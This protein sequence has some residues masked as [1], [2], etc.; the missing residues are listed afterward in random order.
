MEDDEIFAASY[1]TAGSHPAW[2]QPRQRLVEQQKA[3]SF[4]PSFFISN[5]TIGEGKGSLPV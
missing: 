2:R 1:F 4:L 5:K 3:S